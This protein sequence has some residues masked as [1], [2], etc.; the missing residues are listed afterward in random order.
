MDELKEAR[1]DQQHTTTPSAS[2]LSG[3]QERNSD[4]IEVLEYWTDE[5]VITVGGRAVVLDSRPNPFRIKRKPF[6][7][8]SAL[9]DAFQMVGISVVESLA[10]MQEYLWTLQNQR[11]DALRLLTNVITLIR[12]DVDDPDCVRVLPRRTVDRGGPG[13]GRSSSRS[14]RPPPRSP[15]RPSR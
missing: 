5:R 9:P 8:C 14:T 11:I 10:Q 6:V 4:L 13:P 2:R 1:N 7:V 12:S 3:A 15:W